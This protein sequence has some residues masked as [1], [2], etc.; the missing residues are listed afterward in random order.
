[1]PPERSGR[2]NK[3][4]RVEG[5][6]HQRH[7]TRL[8]NVLD[9]PGA[10]G[11]FMSCAR[12]KER[13]AAMDLVEVL[14]EHSAALYGEEDAQPKEA[15]GGTGEAAPSASDDIEAQIRG[16]LAALRA[17]RKTSTRVT[18]LDTDTEC[19]CFVQ[20]TPP[21][22]AARVVA[23]VLEDVIKTGESRSR[24]VQRLAPVDALCRADVDAIRATATQ[25]LPRYFP[26]DRPRTYRIEPR[27][28]SHTSLSRDVLIPL[29]ASCIPD[30][31]AHRADLAH[32]EVVILVEVLKNV[33]GIGAV[34]DYERLGKLNVQTLAQRSGQ[35][36]ATSRVAPTDAVHG[37]KA[38]PASRADAGDAP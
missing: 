36:V 35:A 12:G 21:M 24:F 9:V 37:T 17:P 31:A 23:R 29:V 20:C 8:A 1:M 32:P 26:A 25:V 22:D 10:S 7:R 11:V 38:K 33:C 19:M 30:T 14:C 16:E 27:I 13:K 28:R 6:G 2:A 4:Q 18:A 34:E 3:R 15:G 5:G